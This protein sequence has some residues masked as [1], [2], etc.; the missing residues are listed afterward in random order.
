MKRLVAT[1][2]PL[3]DRRLFRAVY[4]LEALKAA[5]ERSK[6]TKSRPLEL[7]PFIQSFYL[8]IDE[9]G[10]CDSYV[11]SGA[12][13]DGPTYY[14][15]DLNS[16]WRE[17]ATYPAVKS[18]DFDSWIDHYCEGY[19][20]DELSEGYDFEDEDDVDLCTPRH[21]GVEADGWGERISVGQLIEY[22]E[23]SLQNIC[24]AYVRA[25]VGRGGCSFERWRSQRIS[26]KAGFP[27]LSLQSQSGKG[28]W[29]RGKTSSDE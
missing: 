24:P 19:V 18:V 2:S 14:Y 6:C 1:R 4:D 28:E 10:L 7:H 13:G 17:A 15:R 21:G 5:R 23:E 26:L 27:L 29:S 9:N 16:I 12:R 22:F 25:Y 20:D 3:L 11:R 8:E